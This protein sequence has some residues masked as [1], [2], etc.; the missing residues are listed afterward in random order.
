MNSDDFY[1]K[2]LSCLI[3]AIPILISYIT[4]ADISAA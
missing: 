1:N 3:E 2:N 4:A